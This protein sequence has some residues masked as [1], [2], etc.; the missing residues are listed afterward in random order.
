MGSKDKD[1][2]T[3][4]SLAKEIWLLGQDLC[5]IPFDQSGATSF[6]VPRF[7]VA[8]LTEQMSGV[9][10]LAANRNRLSFLVVMRAIVET[11]VTFHYLM[12]CDENELKNYMD[13]SSQKMARKGLNKSLVAGE[14]EMRLLVTPEFN[15]DDYPE[16]NEAVKR[17]T[18]KKSGKPKTRWSE[19]SISDKLE[20]IDRAGKYK[21][22]ILMIE[23]LMI[24]DDASEVLHATLYG[25]LVMLM[26]YTNMSEISLKGVDKSFRDYNRF[27][28]FQLIVVGIFASEIQACCG[29]ELKNKTLEDMGSKNNEKFFRYLKEM[30]PE[31]LEEFDQGYKFVKS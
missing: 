19:T 13:Y 8:L 5:Q 14:K 20:I 22:D 27:I 12:A 11:V 16:I 2:V 3:I 1:Q 21:I 18:G 31:K 29:V 6:N 28:L 23:I 24:Y 17:F 26:G 4:E 30:V 25:Y 7:A 15:L 9:A 10:T